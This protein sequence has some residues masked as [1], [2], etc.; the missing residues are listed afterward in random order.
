LLTRWAST[1]PAA[2]DADTN[3]D[4]IVNALDLADLLAS[5]G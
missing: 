4:G 3:Q 5:W 2:G 1:H